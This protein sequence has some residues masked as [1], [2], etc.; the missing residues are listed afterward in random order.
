MDREIAKG[1]EGRILIKINSM[2]DY[3]LMKKLK[4]ASCAGVPIQMIVRGI[5]CLLPEL[6]GKTENIHITSIV[7]RF[8]EHSRVYCFGSGEQERMYIAS[9][10]FMTRNTERRVEVAC[11]VYDPA[12]RRKIHQILDACLRDTLK[13]RQMRSDGSYCR[14]A[15]E[16][17]FDSQQFLLEQAIRDARDPVQPPQSQASSSL[18]ERLR[19]FLRLES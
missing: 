7:G 17:P 16:P 3:G 6:P 18:L 13:A 4:E 19:R 1:S 2:T 14:R 12:V 9:A 8:L 5:C 15:P 10:D 11:P